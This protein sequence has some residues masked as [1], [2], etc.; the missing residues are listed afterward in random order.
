MLLL[1]IGNISFSELPG[2]V[3]EDQL[4]LSISDDR[5]PVENGPIPDNQSLLQ[6][7]SIPTNTRS[8]PIVI[9]SEVCM[10]ISKLFFM[11]KFTSVSI[12]FWGKQLQKVSR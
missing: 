10:I 8:N 6:N 1:L 2:I 7:Q 3:S 9:G 12:E 5:S 11:L 4:S